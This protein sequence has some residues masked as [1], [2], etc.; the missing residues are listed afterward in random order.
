MSDV[1]KR[2]SALV[3]RA[4]ATQLADADFPSSSLID[5]YRE[6]HKAEDDSTPVPGSLREIVARAKSEG[7]VD[8]DDSIVGPAAYLADLLR[9]VALKEAEVPGVTTERTLLARWPGLGAIPLDK[10]NTVTETQYLKLVNEII[11]RHLADLKVFATDPDQALAAGTNLAVGL[12]AP[13]QLIFKAARKIG[14]DL[15]DLALLD[16]QVNTTAV[17]LEL[18]PNQWV[19]LTRATAS[20][21][22]NAALDEPTVGAA[23]EAGVTRDMF[24]AWG[25]SD[26]LLDEINPHSTIKKMTPKVV[27]NLQR[28]FLCDENA[29]SAISKMVLNATA[30]D[31]ATMTTEN[32]E[33]RNATSEVYEQANAGLTNLL[34]IQMVAHKLGWSL[35]DLCLALTQL[36]AQRFDE[37]ILNQLLAV[38]TLR[39]RF[40]ASIEDSL[41]VFGAVGVGFTL[42]SDQGESR[43]YLQRELPLSSTLLDDQFTLLAVPSQ[44]SSDTRLPLPVLLGFIAHYEQWLFGEDYNSTTIKMSTGFLTGLLRFTKLTRFLDAPAGDV[45]RMLRMLNCQLSSLADVVKFLDYWDWAATLDISIEKLEHIS[46]YT[47]WATCSVSDRQSL[48]REAHSAVTAVL[49]GPAIKE[50]LA[51]DPDSDARATLTKAV[52]GFLAEKFQTSPQRLELILDKVQS[53]TDLDAFLLTLARGEDKDNSPQFLDPYDETFVEVSHLMN[54]VDAVKTFDIDDSSLVFLDDAS[55]TYDNETTSYIVAMRRLS[56]ARKLKDETGVDFLTEGATHAFSEHTELTKPLST[57]TGL[58][59]S[60]TNLLW[61][62]A[63]DRMA[64]EDWKPIVS[65]TDYIQDIRRLSTLC[66]KTGAS[67]ASL[68]ALCAVL[69]QSAPEDDQQTPYDRDAQTAD[70]F[71]ALLKAT[72]RAHDWDKISGEVRAELEEERRDILAPALIRGFNATGIHRHKRGAILTFEMLS[73]VLLVDVEMGGEAMISPIK[74][75][76]NGVQRY[77]RR[78][79]ANEEGTPTPMRLTATEWTWRAHYR[80]WEANRKVF[81]FPENYLDP[82]LRFNK[83]PEFKE[84]ENALLQGPVT[85]D[86]AYNAYLAYLDKLEYLSDLEITSAYPAK[87][88]VPGKDEPV[89]TL[90]VTAKSNRDPAEFYLRSAVVD[91]RGRP[92]RWTAWEKI[93]LAIHAESIVCGFA[94]NRVHV[95]WLD[96]SQR[97]YRQGDKKTFSS[98][99]NIRFS[100]QTL[101][102]GWADPRDAFEDGKKPLVTLTKAE[103][104][105]KW[106]SSVKPE[107]KGTICPFPALDPQLQLTFSLKDADASSPTDPRPRGDLKIKGDLTN[108]EEM[109]TVA[110]DL[111]PDDWS[112]QFFGDTQWRRADKISE[113]LGIKPEAIYEASDV[114]MHPDG[115]SLFALCRTGGTG[116]F[117][118]YKSVDQGLNWTVSDKGIAE[119]TEA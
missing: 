3:K 65:A 56:D 23:F 24:K 94:N 25:A 30:H 76:L 62:N 21:K 93:P 81:L 79:L 29:D 97:Q 59:L 47:C 50:G 26:T 11:T 68:K 69:V 64:K 32:F 91:P 49:S 90:F 61:T 14:V 111:K 44:L 67:I 38:N 63:H 19:W 39:Q 74:L 100:R 117:R 58:S 112:Y 2:V 99:I 85:D 71:L 108:F 103:K 42:N 55:D 35:E 86:T 88:K 114:K 118:I 98:S 104:D 57:L 1:K 20:E 7:V 77:I 36:D 28:F 53:Y 12:S 105:E 6:L 115:Q 73:D 78:A 37:D 106:T 10:H 34:Q 22:V 13:H 87:I 66:T 82:G 27:K 16:A 72:H 18:D 48:L 9:M 84:L 60:E 113:T 41:V 116:R 80:L 95:F 89:N 31:V 119:H 96:Y 15:G 75:A 70:R 45:L 92:I 8:H 43:T 17:R 51:S 33:S 109:L 110:D 54:W 83:T 5:V 52:R 101:S 40:D 102:G 46:T 4:G 107:S